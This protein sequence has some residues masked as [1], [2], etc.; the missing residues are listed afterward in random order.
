MRKVILC[1]PH[2]DRM[3]LALLR[4][5]LAEGGNHNLASLIDGGHSARVRP[6]SD[7]APGWVSIPDPLLGLALI[8][9][10]LDAGMM[11]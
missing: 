4:S 6:G 10:I 11:D 7:P 1:H 9:W 2:I 8:L 5:A 3:G